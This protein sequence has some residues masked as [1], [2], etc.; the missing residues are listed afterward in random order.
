MEGSQFFQSFLF[1]RFAH[2]FQSFD[3]FAQRSLQVLH[4]CDHTF[5]GSSGEVFFYVHL[6]YYFAEHTV[7]R[8]YR[9]FPTRLHFFFAG[10]GTAVEVEVLSFE[11]IA[12]IRSGGIYQSPLQI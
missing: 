9:T 10:H 2:P 12:Q 3:A 6:S 1:G 4:Q 8:A 7:Y 5:F 11:V